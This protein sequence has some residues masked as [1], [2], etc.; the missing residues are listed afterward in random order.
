MLTL[1][2]S[3]RFGTLGDGSP[4]VYKLES[5]LRLA[6]VE[7]RS[8]LLPVP[9]LLGTAPR[10][11]I[12]YVDL[13]GDRIGDSTSIIDQL[14]EKYGDPLEDSRLSKDQERTGHLVKS[15]CEHELFYMMIYGRWIDGDPEPFAN[16]IFSFLPEE[17]RP[18]AIEASKENV[19]QMLHGYRLGRYEPK[20][21]RQA[22]R[23]K[24]AVLSGLL[25]D[26]KW[27]FGPNPSTFD[28]GLF[29]ILASTIHFPIDNPH[30]RIA[31]EY[32]NLVAYCD[33]V[34]REFFDHDWVDGA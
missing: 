8:E 31:R 28:A 27:L 16:R 23:T 20:F 26:N 29:A 14:R 12:P 17:Q 6:G 13:D 19:D 10:G 18:A 3:G 24:L 34:K 30:V 5:W 7:Y 21:V 33:R 22:L 2:R 1:Y 9:E 25:G 32:A 4:F 15:L 11:L